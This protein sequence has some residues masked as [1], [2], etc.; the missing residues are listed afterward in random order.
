MLSR[1]DNEKCI[2]NTAEFD[3]ILR[4]CFQAKNSMT[5]HRGYA[6][7]QLVLG[8]STRLPASLTS[9]EESGAHSLA[10]GSDLESERFR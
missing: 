8:K 1:Y 2:N 5:R 10:M 7:E 4:A 3:M 9:D 6:P